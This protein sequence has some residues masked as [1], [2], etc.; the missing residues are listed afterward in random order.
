MLDCKNLRQSGASLIELL[1]V[2]AISAVL[3]T[4]AATQLGGAG[5]N[6]KRQN[7]AREFKVSL[8]RARFDSVKRRARNIADMSTVTV[9]SAT[10]FSYTLDFNQNGRIDNPA[11]TRLVDFANRT[12]VRIAGTNFVY[13]ITIKF[14]HRGHITVTNGDIPA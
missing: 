3:F 8:E 13:P 10:S 6:L 7:V 14:D 12:D 9:L 4:V 11:E 5:D 2:L 1:V